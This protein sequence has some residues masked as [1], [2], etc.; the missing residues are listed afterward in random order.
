MELAVTSYQSD[1]APEK[2]DPVPTF[3]GTVDQPVADPQ[4]TAKADE[5][6]EVPIQSGGTPDDETYMTR[7][8]DEADP[9]Q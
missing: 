9:D 4:A 3:E 2:D 8:V 5:D 6:R 7:P 1:D